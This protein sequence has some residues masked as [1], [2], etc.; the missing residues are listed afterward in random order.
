MGCEDVERVKTAGPHMKLGLTTSVPES[1]CIRDCL[2]SKDFC[3]T[4]IKKRGWQVMQIGR[5][6]RRGV[7]RNIWTA[8]RFAKECRPASL[9]AYTIPYAHPVKLE[10]GLC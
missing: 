9:V 6:C 5:T 7:W 3:T 1:V 2:I 4:N 10:G 8:S